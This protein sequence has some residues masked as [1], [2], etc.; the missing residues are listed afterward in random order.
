MFG[1]FK[2]EEERPTYGITKPINSWNAVW[3][4]FSH[5]ADMGKDLKR[6]PN[7]MDRIKYLFKK[8]GWLP[9]YLGGYQAAPEVNK[10]GHKKYDQPTGMSLN[11][12]VL[13]QYVLC[14]IG[15]AL[16]LFNTAKFTLPEKA[17]IT[18]LISIVVV[19]CGVLFENKT[20]VKTAEWVRLILYPALLVI[21]TYLNSFT[22][23]FY[24][25]AGVYFTISAVWFAGINKQQHV[26][27]A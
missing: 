24:I 12:Y 2:E 23:W 7:W 21:I 1:T 14:I 8:P 11:L 6:I 15:T 27:V 4:N 26:Q 25:L 9:D 13:F 16:F 19:N 18:V 5:Y 3:A 17:S 10:A 20:W 22:F